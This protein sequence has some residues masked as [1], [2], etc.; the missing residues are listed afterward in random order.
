VVGAIKTLAPYDKPSEQ[1]L[2]I[3]KRSHELNP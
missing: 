1:A 2:L 3:P